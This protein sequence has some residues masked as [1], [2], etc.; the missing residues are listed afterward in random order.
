MVTN[1]DRKSFG[2]PR[3]KFQ[4][5]FRRL[6]PLTFLIRVQAFRDPLCGEFPYVQIFM[7]VGPNPFTWDAQL[8]DYWFSRNPDTVL[9]RPGRGASQVEKSPRLNWATQ[10]L[11]VAHDG[12]SSPNISVRMSWISFGV[13]PCRKK[14]SM[15]ARIF[16]LLKSRTSLDMLPFSRCNKKGLAIRHMN[17]LTFPTT[18]SIP[19]YDI[20]N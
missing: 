14:N 20:G 1:R 12:A 3:K 6:A 17:R 4:M 13:L 18:L 19:S 16:M 10:F 9:G 7:N 8:L 2:S 5:L 11:T 15:T